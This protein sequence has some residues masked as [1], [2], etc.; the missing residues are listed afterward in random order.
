MD[1]GASGP[2]I[3]RR[4]LLTGATAATAS[5]A[6]GLPLGCADSVPPFVEQSDWSP[7]EVAHLLPTVSHRRIRLKVSFRSS[8]P[9]SPVLRVA[10]RSF[11]GIAM[12]SDAHFFAFQAQ[13]L[14]PDTEYELRLGDA[15]GS[16][17]C[18][19]WAIRTFPSPD[20]TPARFRL[21]AYTC[22]GGSDL[23][24]HPL[25]GR[26]FV[27]VQIRRRL[28]ARAL[29]LRPDAVVANGDHVYWDI[30]SRP[31][32]ATGRSPQAWWSAGWFDRAAEVL[33]TENEEVLKKGFGPQIADL[34]GTLFRSVPVFFL[35]DDH[36]YTEND[37]ATDQLRTFP[38]DSFMLAVA[39]ATQ[40]LY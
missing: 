16:L 9:A 12:D 8:R 3:R 24:R 26:L 7:G 10:G 21:L 30:R 33:G 28:L 17:F 38:P 34:Y 25:Y 11:P 37:E 20:A 39:R 15:S 31:G 35:Q 2:R 22:A 27:P 1:G 13:G 19:P 6:L 14:E 29:S 40:R 36:D 23:F 5:L 32:L 4:D 18:D